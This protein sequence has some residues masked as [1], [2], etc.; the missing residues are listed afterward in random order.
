MGSAAVSIRQ[1]SQTH[2]FPAF[3]FKPFVGRKWCHCEIQGLDR[4]HSEMMN[5]FASLWGLILNTTVILIGTKQHLHGH[6]Q[7][8]FRH[9]THRPNTPQLED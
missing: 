9:V 8:S 4:G 3:R 7:A 1:P 6:V 5:H 2:S